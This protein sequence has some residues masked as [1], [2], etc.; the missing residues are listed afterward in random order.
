M[1]LELSSS[2]GIVGVSRAAI[3]PIPLP[4]VAVLVKTLVVHQPGSLLW[5]HE[6][7]ADNGTAP[8]ILTHRGPFLFLHQPNSEKVR[9]S[10]LPWSG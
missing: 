1:Q 4:P 9:G 7:T 10:L 6:N 8:A 5:G 2:L 3:P